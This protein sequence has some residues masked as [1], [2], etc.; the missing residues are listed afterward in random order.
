MKQQEECFGKKSDKDFDKVYQA[1]AESAAALLDYVEQERTFETD[2]IVTMPTSHFTDP[3]RWQREMSEIF[4]KL[5]LC[6]AGT[7]ELREP[8]SYKAMQAVGVPVLMTRARDGVVRAFKNVCAHR[9]APLTDD[10]CGLKKRLACKYHGWTYDLEGRLIGVADAD[11]FGDID[12]ST[13]GLQQLPCAEKNGLIFVSLTPE[14]DG[15]SIDLARFYGDFLDDFAQLNFA[16]WSFLGRRHLTGA[17]WKIA[18]DGYLE[19]YHF[20]ALHPKTVAPRTPSN[21]AHYQAY[22]PHLRIG[23][24]QV[25]IADHLKPVPRADWGKMEHKGYDFIRILF[26][27]VSVFVAGKIT[28]VAQLFPGPTPEQNVTVLNFF[29]R[30]PPA[31]A[32]EEADMERMMDFLHQVVR[33]EDYMIGNCLQ[34]GLATNAFDTVMMGR[35]ER[36]NQYFHEYVDWYIGDR[37]S[38]PEL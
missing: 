37:K 2:K 4:L 27:N 22:G 10:G 9:G 36:G 25:N 29:H 23:F 5:P 3:E 28:Q 1:Y 14:A 17:N 19:A 30:Q 16:E 35:N 31:N 20:A 13:R 24:P 7:A 8:G 21:V 34:K 38:E 32:A 6:L 33:D 11:K 15:G 12:K 26:P 18:F